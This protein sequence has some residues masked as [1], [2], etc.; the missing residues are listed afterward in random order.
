MFIKYK[1]FIEVVES[2]NPEIVRIINLIS[3]T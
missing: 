1:N 3:K 2:K